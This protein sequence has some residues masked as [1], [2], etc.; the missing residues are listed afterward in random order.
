[1]SIEENKEVVRSVYELLDRKE[2]EASYEYYS[3]EFVFHSPTGDW[4]LEQ[5]KQFDT[6][7]F[8]A[9]PDIRVTIEDMVAEADKVS[10]RVTW[11]GTHHG[12][13]RGIA[14]TGNKINITN[15]N[16]YRIIDRKFIEGWNVMDIRFMQ[17]LGTIPSQ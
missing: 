11:K 6:M 16:M 15:A 9:F 12:E 2:L 10:I 3:P 13:F 7:W 17:Q 4:S 14:P 5:A 1:M 8:A